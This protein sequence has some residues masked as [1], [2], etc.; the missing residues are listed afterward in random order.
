MVPITVG[1]HEARLILIRA[2]ILILIS[3]SISS[4][5]PSE[6]LAKTLPEKIGVIVLHP[7]LGIPLMLKVGVKK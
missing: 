4:F 7:K 5:I 1:R 2:N 3:I 6:V